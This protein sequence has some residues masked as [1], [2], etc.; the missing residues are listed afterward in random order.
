MWERKRPLINV[1][2]KYSIYMAVFRP[3]LAVRRNTAELCGSVGVSLYGLCAWRAV[4]FNHPSISLLKG[5]ADVVMLHA[6]WSHWLKLAV[7]NPD[8]RHIIRVCFKKGVQ[9]QTKWSQVKHGATHKMLHTIFIVAFQSCWSDRQLMR[10]VA[11]CRAASL[12]RTPLW[13]S[14]PHPK[15]TTLIKMNGNT[16][17]FAETADFVWIQPVSVITNISI[18]PP[19]G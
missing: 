9:D 14:P 11:W 15:H 10:W 7:H 4:D 1:F 2:C 8:V 3:N 12:Q 17:V 13:S 18:L 5:E 6:W 19:W 16:C